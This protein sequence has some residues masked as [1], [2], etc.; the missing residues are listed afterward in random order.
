M[1]TGFFDSMCTI[2]QHRRFSRLGEI[3]DVNTLI[4]VMDHYKIKKALL[5]S[6]PD[7]WKDSTLSEIIQNDRFNI[8]KHVVPDKTNDEIELDYLKSNNIKA[9]KL[10]PL[11]DKYVLSD[12]VIGNLFKKLNKIKLL[13][14]IHLSVTQAQGFTAVGDR[15]VETLSGMDNSE[16][17]V[18]DRIHTLAE[19][20]PDIP[21]LL[22]RLQGDGGGYKKMMGE[23]LS[24]H[25]NIY[26]ELSH[27][28][29]FKAIE[30]FV[31]LY[32][33]EKLLFGTGLSIQ[34]PGQAI[35]QLNYSQISVN[36]KELIGY[37][38]LER[39]LGQEDL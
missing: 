12:W 14:I 15:M 6:Y 2:G 25:N 36:D 29:C 27:F 22:A 35:A 31:E 7:G 37:K 21:F 10:F 34:D 30:E 20:Y 5:S 16:G 38:N 8:A 11:L 24:R 32:G 17:F 26:I 3:T 33:A 28:H 1:V 4:E 13:T 23:L 39:I 9:V 18:W 19:Q